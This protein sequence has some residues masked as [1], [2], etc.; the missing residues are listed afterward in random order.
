MTQSELH[1]SRRIV[2]ANDSDGRSRVLSDGP[3]PHNVTS[4]PGR[5]LVNLWATDRGG[6]DLAVEDG[7]A[8]PVQLEPPAEGSVFRFFQIAPRAAA[9]LSVD[10]A[11]QAAA[12]AFE[13]MGAGHLRVDTTR[14]PAM[15]KSPTI[16]YIV[17]LKGRVKLLLDEDE[18]VLEP[19]DVVVQRGTNHAWINLVDEPALLVGV[20]LDASTHQDTTG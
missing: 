17:L 15:H 12:S 13:S 8:R 6:P 11:E 3:S 14:H 19:F 18:R 4:G 1:R 9:T 16:D 7:A 10:A 5:G 20:L 2:T